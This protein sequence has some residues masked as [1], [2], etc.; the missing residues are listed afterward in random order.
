MRI[1]CVGGGPAGLYTAVLLRLADPS[2]EVTVVERNPAGVT[3]GW[4]VVF[5]DELLAALQAGDPTTAD[6]IAEAA[7]RWTG[8]VVDV[9]GSGRVSRPNGGFSIGRQRLLDILTERARGLGVRIEFEFEHEP[10]PRSDADLVV[11]AD[12]AGSAHRRAGDFGVTVEVGANKYVWLGTTKVFRSFLFAFVRSDAGWLWCHAYGY[13]QAHSTFI[14]ECSPAT[15][16]GLGLDHMG[17]AEGLALLERLFARH[18]DGHP[19]IGLLGDADAPMPWLSFRTVH[20]ERWRDGDVVLAGDAAHTTHFAIGSGTTLALEDAMTLGRALVD[21]PDTGTALARY[22][23]ERRAALAPR[24]RDAAHSAHWLE[25]LDRYI[26]LDLAAFE[27]LL[28]RRRSA[29]LPR[30]PPRLYVQAR[31]LAERNGITHWLWQHAAVGRRLLA[32]RGDG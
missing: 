11:A 19:L 7:F 30:V 27:A 12:G 23:R 13:D 24:R 26:G 31:S 20:C 15:W 16:Q 2:S 4:G 3:H 14:V 6:Q 17:V 1:T 22:E 8:Q 32:G 28:H 25:D 18:L 5:W 10:G 9:E 29:V 21:E